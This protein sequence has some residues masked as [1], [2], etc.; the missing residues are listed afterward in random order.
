M[1][2][3]SAD[4]C[5][6]RSNRERYGERGYI[7]FILIRKMMLLYFLKFPEICH[8]DELA[9]QRSDLQSTICFPCRKM[10]LSVNNIKER[11]INIFPNQESV[12]DMLFR[13]NG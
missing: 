7:L 2:L 5:E 3:L 11:N 4:V 10:A 9:L 12:L 6:G 1:K 13:Y 8:L